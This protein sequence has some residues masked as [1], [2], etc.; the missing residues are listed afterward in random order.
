[1]ATPDFIREIRASAGHQLLWLPGVS[2]VV[3]DD[4]GRVLLGQRADNHRWALIS[5]IPDP[6]EQ[7]ALAIVREVEEETGVRVAVERMVAVR[8]GRQVTYPNGDICQFMDLCF[9]CRALGGEARVNDDES[10]AVGWFAL[11]DL[12]E[13]TDYHH[14]RI[15]QA[16]SDEPTWFE[17]VTSQ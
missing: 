11:D 10:L 8:S 14:F 3:F 4:E 5:G 13:L 12:P 17:P 15:K 1:M 6:G 2:A 9:R 7:P 16:L